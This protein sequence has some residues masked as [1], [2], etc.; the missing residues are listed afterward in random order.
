[1]YELET[2]IEIRAVAYCSCIYKLSKIS[3]KHHRDI[4]EKEY[5]KIL[6]DCVV[7]KGSDCNSVMLDHVSSFKGEPQKVKIKIVE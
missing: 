3:G 6:K 7:F 1:M 2:F 4:T 5:Q